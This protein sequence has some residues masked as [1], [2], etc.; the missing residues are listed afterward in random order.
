[1]KSLVTGGAGYFGRL[2]VDKLTQ[3][4]HS[5]RVF[6]LNEVDNPAP[7]LE[8]IRGDIRDTDAVR[9]ACGGMDLV[10]HNVAQVPLA[11]DRALFRSVNIDG[12][13][14]LLS[15]SLEAGVRKVIHTSTSAVYGVPKHNPV[16]ELT[17]PTPMEAYGRA[18]LEGEALCAEFGRRGLDYSIIRPRTIMGHGR[19]GIFQILFEWIHEGY[20]VPVFNGGH[21]VYQF[22]HADDLAEACILSGLRSGIAEYNCGTDRFGTLRE[23]LKSL[24]RHAATGSRVRSLPMWPAVAGMKLASAL[25]LSPLGAYHALMYGRS[26]YFDSS[27]AMSELS[28]QPK[29]SNQEMFIDS[30][31]WYLRNRRAVLEAKSGASHHRSAVKQGLLSVVKRVL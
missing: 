6:D 26:L 16:T 31:E 8:L 9:K 25:G 7:E 1:M 15:A 14:N 10:F 13:R 23:T 28:W 30:Y 29:Y 22:V 18:K 17:A 27:K 4:G 20:N 24:C 11:K 5:V 2:L 21:N 3:R 12:T 19:L